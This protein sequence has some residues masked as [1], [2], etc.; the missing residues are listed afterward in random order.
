MIALKRGVYQPIPC[1][2]KMVQR[3][4]SRTYNHI[5]RNKIPEELVNLYKEAGYDFLSI[6][7]HSIVAKTQH[8]TTPDFLMVPGEEICIGTSTANTLFHIVA[9]G[10]EKTLPFRDFDYRLNPQELLTIK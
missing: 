7:D 4:C 6:T 2:W 5:R 10:I 9:L 3:K 8:L 1:T